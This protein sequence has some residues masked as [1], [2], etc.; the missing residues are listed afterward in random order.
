[1]A[2]TSRRCSTTEP[3]LSARTRGAVQIGVFIP[4]VLLFGGVA[5]AFLGWRPGAFVAIAGAVLTF[6]WQLAVGV[7][8]YRRTMSRPWPKVPPIEDDDDW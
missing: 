3:E 1:M 7:W 6:A 4:E 8:S 5:A 2:T